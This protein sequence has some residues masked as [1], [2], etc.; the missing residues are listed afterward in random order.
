MINRK[1]V[2]HILLLIHFCIRNYSLFLMPGNYD[3]HKVKSITIIFTCSDL[4][5]E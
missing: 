4:N 3:M 5:T 2:V 1:K